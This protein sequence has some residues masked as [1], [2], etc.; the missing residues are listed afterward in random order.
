MYEQTIN[1]YYT[2]LEY[3]FVTKK[4]SVNIYN[5]YKNILLK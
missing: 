2:N 1:K 3:Y 5:T 4:V